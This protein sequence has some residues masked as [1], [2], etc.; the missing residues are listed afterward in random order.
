MSIKSRL[1]F[2]V[3][4][5]VVVDTDVGAAVISGVIVGVVVVGVFVNLHC[6]GLTMRV[7]RRIEKS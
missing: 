4:A 6:E 2:G 1:R 3:D 5:D 7:K